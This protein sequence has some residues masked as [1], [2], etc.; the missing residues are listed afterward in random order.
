MV[1]VLAGSLIALIASIALLTS[2][3]ALQQLGGNDRIENAE[4]LHEAGSVTVFTAPTPDWVR[5]APSSTLVPTS[6]DA[7][8]EPARLRL[9]DEQTTLAGP[10]PITVTRTVAEAVNRFGVQGV[11]VYTYVVASQTAQFHLLE[12]AVIRDGERVDLREDLVIN[13][14]AA[15]SFDGQ[16]M[17]GIDQII[18][19]VPG[20]RPGDLVMMTHAVVGE[21]PDGALARSAVIEPPAMAGAD[22][23]RLTLRTPGGG[24]Q[25]RDFAPLFAIEERARGGVTERVYVDGA[26]TPTLGYSNL[27]AWR[28]VNGAVSASVLENWAPI[29]QWAD[30]L[31]QPVADAQVV[32]IAQEIRARHSAQE[33]QAAAALFWVQREIRYFAEVLGQT[34]YMP[35]HPSRT[36]RLREGDCKAKSLLLISLL[37]ELGV[38]ADAALVHTVIGPGLRDFAPSVGAFNH[39]IVTFTLDGERYWL[40]PTNYE[41]AGRLAAVGEAD[42]GYALIADGS[43]TLTDMA[44]PAGAPMIALT[45]T[46]TLDS[47]ASGAS[48]RLE[49]RLVMRGAMTDAV[50]L[51]DAYQGREQTAR[52]MAGVMLGERFAMTRIVEAPQLIFDDRE[53]TLTATLAAEVALPQVRSGA[54]LYPLMLGFA[55]LQPPKAGRDM[56]VAL[57]FPYHAEH[58]VEIELTE[59]AAAAWPALEPVWVERRNPAFAQAIAVDQDGRRISARAEVRMRAREIGPAAFAEVS[60][61]QER[62]MDELTLTFGAGETQTM[63]MAALPVFEHMMEFEPPAA[64]QQH[65]YAAP[66]GQLVPAW[67]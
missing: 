7:G 22:H 37:A 33:D 65:Y 45:D 43:P 53:N 29:A 17:V 39:V 9:Y 3:D 28:P 4:V 59:R 14:S 60:R 50:R 23:V 18:I 19:R 58:V 6:A 44:S 61:D 49:A 57:R 55:P 15:Q 30:G 40:D 46:L 54:A 16:I 34:G 52:A 66:P 11:S 32:E 51:M 36:L 8:G 20:V 24:A 27:P 10:N 48:G 21:E 42:F 25:M 67:R 38:E 47:T 31:Y 13:A 1:R 35:Q 2:A 64:P 26:Y 62:S 56:P 5:P 63:S 12:A 41:Q